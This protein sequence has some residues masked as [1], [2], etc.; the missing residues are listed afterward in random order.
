[1]KHLLPCILLPCPVLSAMTAND[2]VYMINTEPESPY[3]GN[4]NCGTN[5]HT[6]QVRGHSAGAFVLV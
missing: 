4:N 2:F 6:S 3:V 5:E 1:M